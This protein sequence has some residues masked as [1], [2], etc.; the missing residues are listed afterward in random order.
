MSPE[1]YRQANRFVSLSPE[2][3][4]KFVPVYEDGQWKSSVYFECHYFDVSLN[5]ATGLPNWTA[6]SHVDLD[7]D[8][9]KDQREVVV[10]E[11]QLG[12][13]WN[14][15]SVA[16]CLLRKRCGDSILIP[17]VM[18]YVCCPCAAFPRPAWCCA[19]R[20]H[21]ARTQS[22]RRQLRLRRMGGMCAVS[23]LCAL[24]VECAP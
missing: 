8:S 16:G 3:K 18:Q 7:G 17:G 24:W 19:K 4:T 22:S 13:G 6:K 9:E 11:G 2:Y 20:D 12:C 23:A 10:D 21:A 5:S 14:S 1:G 15:D